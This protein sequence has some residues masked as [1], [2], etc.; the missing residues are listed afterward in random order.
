VLARTYFQPTGLQHVLQKRSCT[1]C[2]PVM[3]MRSSG[4]PVHTL[5]LF[6]S[7]HRGGSLR[8]VQLYAAGI[9]HSR[10][11]EEVGFATG[12]LEVLH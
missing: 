1:T 2:S 4:G 8:S 7:S 6:D 9:G 11:V 10:L 3:S 5:T 12:A